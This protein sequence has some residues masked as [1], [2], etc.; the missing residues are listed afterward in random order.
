MQCH[1][2]IQRNKTKNRRAS[3]QGMWQTLEKKEKTQEKGGPGSDPPGGGGAAGSG[4]PGGAAG[5]GGGGMEE[6]SDGVV[7]DDASSLSCPQGARPVRQARLFIPHEVS[8]L[9]LRVICAVAGEIYRRFLQTRD[10]RSA[11]KL[12]YVIDFLLRNLDVPTKSCFPDSHHRSKCP[13]A[14]PCIPPPPTTGAPLPGDPDP[15]ASPP[16][17]TGP[18]SFWL[19]APP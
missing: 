18:P 15:A 13:S 7:W 3:P 6:E 16:S 9:S 1:A 2:I 5:G 8:L 4:S 17:P 14:S 19:R 12:V 10:L 11:C